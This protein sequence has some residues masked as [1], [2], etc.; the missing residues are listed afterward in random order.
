M[1]SMPLRYNISNWHQ[2]EDVRSNNSRDL[3]IHVSDFIQSN[4][5]TGTRIQITHRNYGV[6]FACVLNAHGNLVSD[7]DDELAIELT[8]RQILTELEKYGFLVTYEPRKHLPGDQLEYL[9]TL[10]ELGY[11]KIRIM[12]VWKIINGVK[13]FKWYVVV[14][15]VKNNIDWINNG[16]SSSESEFSKAIQSGSA[17]NISS[18]SKTKKWSW[19]WLDYVANIDD[20][21]KD[22]A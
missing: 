7:Y 17:I 12:N 9:I 20:I 10:K 18:I 4:V 22:N 13:V 2:L 21:L 6:V 5:L 19:N 1:S 8:T 11:D 16:F 15:N 3:R 14:F